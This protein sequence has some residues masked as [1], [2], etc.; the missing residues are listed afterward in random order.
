MEVCCF[1]APGLKGP[2]IV[3]AIVAVALLGSAIGGFW[4]LTRRVEGS[5]FDSEGVRIHF[6]DEGSGTPVVLLHGFAV[7]ADL[8]WRLPGL[9]EA[10]AREFRVISM[11]L[12]GH[13]LS[14]KP[15]DP[16][17]YGDAMAEDVI[18]L[19]DHLGIEKV[20][21]AGYSLG[22]IITLKLATTHPDR[23][24]SASPLGAGWENPEDSTFLV[25]L[26]GI[27][28][29]LESGRGVPP[30]S[31][32]LG[33][34]REPPGFLHTIWVR[35]MTGCLND[36]RALAAMVRGIRGLT[37]E[38]EAVG[39]ISVPVC[40]IVGTL[41]PMKAGVD[42]MVGVVPDHTVVF[43]E[44]ADHLQAPRSAELAKALREFLRTHS[45][46]T[47]LSKDARE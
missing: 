39:R 44:G 40:S 24:L 26:A 46:G 28:E 12:R 19:L 45:D 4:W 18:A 8:N 32:S 29:A 5:Y 21:L 10:L 11:D 34:E 47:G 31:A 33:G 41:D 9:T 15:H 35:V 14:G 3:A 7:N 25:A 30:L 38:R 22:G 43:L 1:G 17:H 6:T 23:L 36:G 20:H 2:A 13:G 16:E 42:A 37:V 27:A